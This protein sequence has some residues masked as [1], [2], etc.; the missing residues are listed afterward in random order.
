[1]IANI[2]NAPTAGAILEFWRA[3]EYFT[4]PKIDTQSSDGN[5]E[6]H[7]PVTCD[8]DFPWVNSREKDMIEDQEFY[9]RHT[10]YFGV[11]NVDTVIGEME[12]KLCPDA[13]PEFKEAGN[14]KCCLACVDVASHGRSIEKSFTPASFV[15]AMGRLLKTKTRL[16]LDGFDSFA[17]QSREDFDRRAANRTAPVGF[18]EIQNELDELVTAAGWKPRNI[19]QEV[20]TISRKM[21]RS[22]KDQEKIPQR[23]DILN[24]FIANDLGLVGIAIRSNN[25]GVALRAYLSESDPMQR[26]GCAKPFTPRKL[27]IRPLASGGDRTPGFK[28]AT[29]GQCNKENTRNRLRTTCG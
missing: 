21:R 12:Q 1:M 9:W 13:P 22:E 26:V 4:P 3:V 29:R 15:W 14:G 7:F 18:D 23:Q 19:L 27:P 6:K 5:T 24:S 2:K 10:L 17:I 16:R 28:P 11:I 8:A 20:Y 25:I